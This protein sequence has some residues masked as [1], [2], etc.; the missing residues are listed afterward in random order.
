MGNLSG[1]DAASV[2]GS[3]GYD[4]IP[5]GDYE[6][7]LI[8][9]SLKTSQN[10]GKYISLVWEIISG[11]FAGRRIYDMAMRD[12]PNAMA[13]QIGNRKLKALVTIFG[14]ANDTAEWNNRPCSLKIGIRE[15][16]N[17]G[18]KENQINNYQPSGSGKISE[19]KAKSQKPW[20]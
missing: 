11:D 9:S 18:E 1:F 6:G 20:G 4:A 2:E 17:T 19:P 12:H 13:V 7:A 8:E 3:L 14:P 10:G 5:A 15:N 16:K